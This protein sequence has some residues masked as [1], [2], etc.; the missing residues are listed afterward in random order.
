MVFA[1]KTALIFMLLFIIGN[2]AIAL[3]YMVKSS[4]SDGENSPSMSQF[5]GRR[6]M[7][8]VGVV[9]LLIIAL[10]SGLIEPNV[11]PY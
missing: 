4:P 5:L 1:F 10:S 2:L 7:V 3:Y 6:L 11:R 8:S 9:I